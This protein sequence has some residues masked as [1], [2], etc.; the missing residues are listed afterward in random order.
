MIKEFIGERMKYLREM[1][2]WTQL[3][4]SER[5]NVSRSYISQLERGEREPTAG[6]LHQIAEAFKVPV[7]MFF[8]NTRFFPFQAL[9]KYFPEDVVD[10]LKSQKNL[11]YVELMMQ[12]S[13]LEISP[14]FIGEMIRM[15]RSG[16]IMSE[17]GDK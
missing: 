8:P 1:K 16:R 5:A 2:N 13:E 10:F 15:V 11:P 3:E 14:Q 12:A 9:E 6:V 7:D 17:K 4:L